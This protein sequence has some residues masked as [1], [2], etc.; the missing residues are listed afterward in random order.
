LA[1]NGFI[2]ED[3]YEHLPTLRRYATDCESIVELGVRTGASTRAFLSA[4]PKKLCSVDIIPMAREVSRLNNVMDL[5]TQWQYINNDDLKID[6]PEC[7]LLFIDTYH[8]YEQL[9]QEFKLHANKAKKYIIL[10]DT[11]TWGEYGHGGV[12]GLIYAVKEFLEGN[13]NWSIKEEF[14]NNNG[15]MVLER[16]NLKLKEELYV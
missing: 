7:D 2:A 4:K 9:I 10:H 5:S 13:S 16:N 3:I 11:Y 14:K 6:I 12:K 15:L 1:C 8:T